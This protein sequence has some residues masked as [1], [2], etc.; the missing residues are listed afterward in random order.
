MAPHAQPRP[1]LLSRIEGLPIIVVFLVLLALFMWLAPEVFLQ[2]FQ[3]T[4]FLST[5]PPIIL[6]AVGLTFIIGAGEIDLCF[7]AILGVSGFIFAV[8]FKE[9]QSDLV[10]WLGA[11]DTDWI[12]SYGAGQIIQWFAIVAALAGGV[13]VG[14]V[15]GILVAVIG[16][17]SF[18][19]TLGTQFLWY[20]V[21]SILS[22]G[23]SY[24]LRG[25]EQSTV[26]MAVTGR[27]FAGSSIDW[28]QQIPIQSLWTTLIV[29]FMWFILN[30]HRF[31]E[32]TLFL[33]DSNAVSKVVG[34][35]VVRE[36]IKLFT[37]MGLLSGV[38]AIFLT[39]ENKNYFGNQGQGYLLIA[40]ASVLIGGTSI[41]GG[42]AT[43]VGTIFGCF[44]IAL[45]EPGLVAA[46][47]TGSWVNAARGLIFLIAIVFYLY[48]DEPQRRSNFL[49]RLVRFRAFGR[50]GP[51]D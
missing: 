7:P 39:L 17:P 36:K 8:I 32:H 2:P 3:Y 1:S 42:R 13:V 26:W 18:I 24:A 43:I 34:I 27:P 23:K 50:A 31:G 38:A 19:A 12:A 41:F 48:V 10:S 14:Y 30:R 9:G 6:L 25:A 44:I 16:I 33:G 35:D 51:A 40:I 22:G 21:A 5:L 45:V 46:G 20:G 15:N 47:L 29:I 28:V 4:T 11:K 37:L 49:A